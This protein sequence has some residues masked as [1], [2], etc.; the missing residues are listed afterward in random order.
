MTEKKKTVKVSLLEKPGGKNKKILYLNFTPAIID[1]ATGKPTRREFP[2]LSIYERPRNERET[3]HNKTAREAAEKIRAIRQ[4]Q[5]IKGEY[6]KSLEK[7]DADF[8]AYFKELADQRKGSNSDNWI[9]AYHY[10]T[11]FTGGQPVKFADLDLQFCEDF[12]QH[13]F[14][15]PTNRSG[16]TTL[17]QNSVVSYFNKLK[18]ALKQAYKDGFLTTDLNAR[19]GN[20]KQAETHR[21]FLSLE[22]LQK[23]AN[24]DCDDPTLKR[25][26]IFSAL[27]GLRFSDIQKLTWGEVQQSTESGY[28]LQFKQKKTGGAETLPIGTQAAEIMGERGKLDE[29]VFKGLVYSAWQN[30]KLKRWVLQ[31]GIFKEITFHSFRHT[32]ATLQLTLGTDIYT[33]SKMLGHKDLKTTMIYGKIVD[34][35]KRDAANKIKLD[36]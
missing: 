25:A 8:V 36:L 20:V 3:A 26:A 28:Y 21:Q 17:A 10:L 35:K 1:P 16:K 18:A 6:G 2:G 31:A 30:L 14:S 34:E 32:Y 24:T 33:V 19:V 15:A 27:T 23:L 22:E 29:H 13:L 4:L 11:D 7:Q 12:R 9:S 5:I